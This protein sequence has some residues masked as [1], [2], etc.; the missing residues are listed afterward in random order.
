M[1]VD[2]SVVSEGKGLRMPGIYPAAQGCACPLCPRYAPPGD[3]D[4]LPRNTGVPLPPGSWAQPGWAHIPS[5]AGS[6][7]SLPDT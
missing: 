3:G 4:G 1:R 5:P 2:K 7:K 6:D